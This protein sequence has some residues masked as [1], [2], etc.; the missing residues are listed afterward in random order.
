MGRHA[1]E[2]G[3]SNFQQADAGTYIAR[4]FKIVDI[5]TH[6][7]EYQK[8]PNVRNQVIVF[9][10]LPTESIDVDGELKPLIVSKFYTNS[11]N[12]MATLRH[13]L[14]SWRGREFTGEELVGFD[15]MNLLG[16]PCMVT[17]VKNEKDKSKISS[18]SGMPKGLEC[19]PQVNTD[20]SFFIDEWNETVFNGL[21]DGLKKLI[22][23]SDEYKARSG[24]SV[25]SE[26]NKD[27]YIIAF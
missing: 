9:W 2:T 26:S 12:E 6:H 21:S 23:E 16:K 10:E 22:Q 1:K 14:E 24:Q 27:E 8:K 15:L 18:V 20:E 13:D 19:P 25:V 11:L 3:G 5:G 4:C 7:G 17:V